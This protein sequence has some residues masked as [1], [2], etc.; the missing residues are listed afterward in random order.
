M[1]D[2]KS[3]ITVETT[4][5]ATIE[6]VWKTWTTPADIV[7]FNNPLDDWHTPK[8]ELD[9]KEGG[10]FFYRMEM[11]D[12]SFGFD[13]AGKYDKIITNELIEST[14]N[15]G[16]K[17][18]NKFTSNGN[19]TTVTEIFEPDAETPLEVQRAFVQTILDNFKKYVENKGNNN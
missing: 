16:R 5:N 8:V 4:V 12:G 15:D 9:L 17:T 7:Q 10:N 3:T 2:N 14:G 19:E 1:A 13:F 18:I 11:K 6:N